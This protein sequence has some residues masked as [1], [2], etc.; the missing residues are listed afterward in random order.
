MTPE[1]SR[2]FERVR[3]TIIDGLGCGAAQD[4]RTDYPDDVHTNSLANASQIEPLD[5]E[6]LQSMGL[7]YIDGLEG[8]KVK[9]NFRISEV[10]GAFG[11][12]EPTFKG[13]GSPEGHQTL[14]GHIVDKP[15]LLFDKTGFPDEIVDLVRR[16]ATSVLGREIDIIRYPGTDDVNGEKFV[17]H[18][19]IGPVHLASGRTEGPLK[20]PIYASSDSLIQI[21]LHQGVVPQAQIEEIGMAVRRAVNEANYRIGRI[22]MRPFIGDETE[23]FTRVSGDRKD[24]GVDPDGPTLIDHLSEAGIHVC[25]I[26]KA[27]SMLNEHGFRHQDI[28][29]LKSDEERLCAILQMTNQKTGPFFSFDNLVA[30]DESYGHPRKPREYM[31]HV[32]MISSW[33]REIMRAMQPRDLWILVGDH[34]NDPTQNLHNNHTRE[35]VKLL[36]YSPLMQGG[37]DLGQRASFADVAKTIAENYGIG[38]EIKTGDSFLSAL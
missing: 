10:K 38:D 2:Q 32:K 19:S 12:L 33:A 37:V 35:K 13:N 27:A 11:S 9:Q 20:F 4:A 8:M 21:A 15:Y 34:G 22:I 3:V 25:G 23:G 36:A 7:E 28:L 18:P 26:G 30:T 17:N 14:M 1:T 31:N 6:A 16:T 5:A 29:K 24:Y